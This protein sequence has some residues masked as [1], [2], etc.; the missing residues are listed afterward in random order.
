MSLSRFPARGNLQSRRAE[1]YIE[2]PLS[3]ELRYARR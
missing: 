3:A 2:G 1:T